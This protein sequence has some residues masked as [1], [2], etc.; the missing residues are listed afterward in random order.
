MLVV[1]KKV[2]SVKPLLLQ[3]CSSTGIPQ[4]MYWGSV[5][6]PRFLGE[7]IFASVCWCVIMKFFRSPCRIQTPN[8]PVSS[9]ACAENFQGGG[10]S[11][12]TIA[13]RHKSALKEVPKAR[14][15]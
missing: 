9:V 7:M 2:Y 4:N 6:V 3:Q 5:R 13:W 8:R 14:P 11:F 15:F 1:I 12:V 10:P